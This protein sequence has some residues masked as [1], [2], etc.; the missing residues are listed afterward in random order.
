MFDSSTDA[1][2]SP[3]GYAAAAPPPPPRIEPA[4]DLRPL[5]TGEILDRTFALYRQRFWLYTG[6]S[7]FAAAFATAGQLVQMIWMGMPTIAPGGKVTPAAA[8]SPK[9]A[10][11]GSISYLA[12]ALLTWA[13]YSITQAATVSAVSSI[14]LGHETSMGIAFR[15]VR[16]KWWRYMLIALWQ[17]WSAMWIFVLLLIP[18][19]TLIALKV[20]S[21]LS[22]GFF[23]IFLAILSLI[24]GIIAYIR[25][26]LAIAASVFE[27]LPIRASMR[28][29]KVLSANRKWPIFLLLL[30][31]FVL[32]L[33]AGVLQAPFSVMLMYSH[34]GQKI[35]VQGLSLIMLF[36]TSSLVGP[37]GA[38]GLCLFYIDGRVRKEGF[39]I[40]ALMDRTLGSALPRPVAPEPVV[41]PSGFARSGF[42]ASPFPP[43]GL[44]AAPP[45]PA[46]PDASPFAP[47]GFTAPSKPKTPETS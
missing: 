7:A 25:N 41:L 20:S 44:T 19:F 15:A 6:L 26:S 27:R 39:D 29:S 40:E 18:A 36:L 33:V 47:S 11:I 30:I 3:F 16:A 8:S 45:S 23:L 37:V 31:L 32:R 24:Y 4:Y 2:G 28:R 12:I 42:T 22:I 1:A 34:T 5:S 9:A 46:P 13:A 10:I 14:Y 38:I 21:L 17:T 35:L 43:S